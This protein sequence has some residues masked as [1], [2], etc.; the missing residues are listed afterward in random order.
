MVDQEW[1]IAIAAVTYAYVITMERPTALVALI[2]KMMTRTTTMTSASDHRPSPEIDR[3]EDARRFYAL[4]AQDIEDSG[5]EFQTAHMHLGQAIE[6]HDRLKEA[7]EQICIR[8]RDPI[9]EEALGL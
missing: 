2:V 3:L 4:F 8:G 6:E 1:C 9:A 5:D 7:L